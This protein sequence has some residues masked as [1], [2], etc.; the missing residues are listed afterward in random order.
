MSL[1]RN[2]PT[3]NWRPGPV[4]HCWYDDEPKAVELG[5]GESPASEPET[6]ALLDLVG[7]MSPKA[8]ISIHSRLGC[9]NDPQES[10]LGVWLSRQTGLR[11]VRDI[12]YPTP[13]SFGT[14]AGENKVSLITLELPDESI[15]AIRRK[16]C[17]I[18]E[19][20]LVLQDE[21]D[22]FGASSNPELQ[23]D[24]AAPRR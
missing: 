6:R 10:T 21:D 1:N 17:P 19:R 7:S 8:V 15:V 23:T 2:F 4:L 14:W 18:L 22:L 16:F 11:L 24:G 5:T 9:V 12:G 13:G 20:L 3:A